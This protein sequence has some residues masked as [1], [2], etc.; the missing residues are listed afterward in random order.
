MTT[1]DL[2]EIILPTFKGVPEVMQNALDKAREDKKL[3]YATAFRFETKRINEPVTIAMLE[4]DLE[5]Y[6]VSNNNGV[7]E[8]VNIWVDTYNMA[9]MEK[10]NEEIDMPLGFLLSEFQR[11]L[12]GKTI[13]HDFKTFADFLNV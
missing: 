7:Q 12:N 8:Y 11:Y 10:R 1:D 9:C 2:K 3:I 4:L 6:K 13:W 5:V